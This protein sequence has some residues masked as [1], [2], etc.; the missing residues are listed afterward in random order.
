VRLA[1]QLAQVNAV[2]FQVLALLAGFDDQER[3]PGVVDGREPVTAARAWSL[4]ALSA[5]SRR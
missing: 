2:R 4:D 3:Q 5:T 1:G